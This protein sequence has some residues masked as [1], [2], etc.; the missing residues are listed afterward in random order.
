MENSS[1]QLQTSP[2]LEIRLFGV[3]TLRVQGETLLPFRTY[4]SGALLAYLALRRGQ[5]VD[6]SQ[7]ATLLWPDSEDPLYNMRRSLHELRN[8]LGQ[9]RI[10]K[11]SGQTIAL[12]L[13]GVFCDYLRFDE[14]LRQ[15]AAFSDWDSAIEM[16]HGDLMAGIREDWFDNERRVCQESYRKALEYL[17]G[18]A[19]QRCDV[20]KASAYLWRLLQTTPL[21][22]SALRDLMLLTAE[23]GN[24]AAALEIYRAHRKRVTTDLDT[25]LSDDLKQLYTE[26]QERYRR[27]P[28]GPK[29]VFIPTIPRPIETP[30][31]P[32]PQES[33]GPLSLSSTRYVARPADAEFASA[34]LRQDSI[35]LL[36]GARQT[37][38][39][40]LIARGLQEA[41]QADHRTVSTPLPRFTQ[42]Q[43][44]SSDS[45]LR[46]LAENL[47]MGL[48]LDAEPTTEFGWRVEASPNDN[49]EKFVRR[50]VLKVVQKPV[51]WALDE[52][53]R[54]FRYDYR[55]D[56]FGLFRSWHNDRALTPNSPWQQL[57]LIIS[58]AS[59][60]HLLV[61][62]I[63]QSPFNVGTR[64]PLVDFTYDKFPELNERNGSPLGNERALLDFHE[65]VG[66][67]P[68]LIQT[69]LSALTRG[70]ATLE[71]LRAS[72]TNLDGPF[73]NHLKGL[74]TTVE[75]DEV[76][77][78]GLRVALS[79][80]LNTLSLNTFHRLRTAGLLIGDSPVDARFRAKV[81]EIFFRGWL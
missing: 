49:F 12:D 76:L 67:H 18:V 77:R 20:E 32:I 37:G 54:L 61:K 56:I 53:D 36:K 47:A 6:R 41:R 35:I 65:L 58:Y 38:K 79:G 3:P 31:A 62:D 30:P 63:N 14:I 43:M 8:A 52:V 27:S 66:G 19:R 81:Y 80:K 9:D 24:P 55:D 51:V 74:R 64:V 40:S 69:G 29:T 44:S 48:D 4:K 26:L 1:G 68:Y 34:I 73:G 22:D 33:D 60:A 75:G 70:V 13:D 2:P 10:Y 16:Y 46:A 71:T 21:H 17:A 50:Q 11:V 45:F 59:E 72:V 39:T 7:V 57:T 78:E 28:S 5:P 42:E 25:D 23:N 15:P